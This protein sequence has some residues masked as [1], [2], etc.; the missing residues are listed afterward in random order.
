MGLLEDLYHSVIEAH[1]DQAAE[2]TRKA[3]EKF[4]PQEILNKALKPAMDV[5]GEEYERGIRYIP[6]MLLSADAMKKA[7]EELSPLLT[8]SGVEPEGVVIIGT[9]EGDFHDIGENLVSMMLEGGGFKVHSLGVDVTAESFIEA[10]EREK[11][12]ILAMSALLTSTMTCMPKVIEGLENSGLRD[13]VKV[14]IGGA[15]VTQDYATKIGADGYG[16]D[17]AAAVRVARKLLKKLSK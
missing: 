1:K 16:K 7:M 6:E 15:P 4:D 5:V 9:V 8:E 17:A 2:L 14:M 3:L 13:H 12:N 11:P 10:V